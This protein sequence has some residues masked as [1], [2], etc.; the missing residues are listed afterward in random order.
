MGT[1]L[2]LDA[3]NPNAL[4][5]ANEGTLANTKNV[6]VNGVCSNLELTDQKPFMAPADFTATAASFSK[7]VTDAEFATMVLPFAAALPSGVE[8][9]EITG[10]TGNVLTTSN[11]DAI[12]ANKPVMLKNAG[13]YAFTAADVEVKAANG[14]QTNGLLNGVYATTDVPTDNGYVLQK[15]GEDVNFFKAGDGIKV[16]AFRAYLTATAGARLA[17]DFNEAT[18]IAEMEKVRNGENE[19]FYNLAGQRVVKAQKGLYITNGKKVF[20]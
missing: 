1:G 16:N 6:I 11:V 7:T 15:Q 17:F 20:K 19:T 9:F 13:A 3:A 2:T 18:G 8:A 4:F 10:N 14:V 12:E 5:I